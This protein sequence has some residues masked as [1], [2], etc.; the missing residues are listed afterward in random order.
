MEK[1]LGWAPK[2]VRWGHWGYPHLGQT[3]LAR[4]MQSQIWHQ[5]ACS[6]GGGG[7]RKETMGCGSLDF[8]QH[9]TGFS[10]YAIGAFQ[11]ATPVLAFRGS[12]SE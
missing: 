12:E 10:Y 2:L 3:M 5:V 4:L 11:A 8:S 7:F 1:Q 9:A 6:V